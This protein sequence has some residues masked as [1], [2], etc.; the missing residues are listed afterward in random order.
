MP[1]SHHLLL[2]LAV[3][4]LL[5]PSGSAA[6]KID[7]VTYVGE[8]RTNPIPAAVTVGLQ[9]LTK[10]GIRASQLDAGATDAGGEIPDQYAVA[11]A[12]AAGR[13]PCLVVQAGERVVRI[14]EG[15]TTTDE[16]LEAAK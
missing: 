12:A 14:V 8:L 11:M 1:R 7:Q 2:L 9:L 15:P 10:H 6:G 13:M 3:L 4:L 5:M 16:V